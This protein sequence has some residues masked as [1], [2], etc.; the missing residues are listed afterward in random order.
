MRIYILYL[1]VSHGYI[2]LANP[3]LNKSITKVIYYIAYYFSLYVL[4][5]I[6]FICSPL[7]LIGTISL[8]LMK[9][10][11]YFILFMAVSRCFLEFNDLSFSNLKNVILRITSL[12]FCLSIVGVYSINVLLYECTIYYEQ[13]T[14]T[15]NNTYL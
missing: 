15:I 4:L 10:Y 5:Y 2:P 12:F 3:Y 11:T 6:T 9:N 8:L 7:T 14:F 1:L 13:L